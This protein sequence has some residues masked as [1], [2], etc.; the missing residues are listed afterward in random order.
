MEQ[1][2]IA[3][4]GPT[5]LMLACELRLAGADP[6]VIERLAAP[7]GESRAGGLHPRTLEILDMRGMIEPFL[8]EGRPLPGGHFAG[9]RLDFSGLDTKYPYLLVILQRRI[10]RL[11][12]AHARSLGVRF[13]REASVTGFAQRDDDVLIES[14]AGSLRAEYLVGC[15]GGRSTIRRSA[16]IE[17]LGTPPTMTAILGDVELAAPP[18]EPFFQASGEGGVYSVLVFEPGWYRVITNE[19]GTVADRDAPVGIDELR[20]TMVRLAGTDFGMHS[21]RWVSRYHDGARLASAYRAGRVLLAGDAAHIHYPAGGQGLNTGIQDAVNLGWKLAAVVG[22]AH[23]QDLLDSYAVERRPVAS[24]VLDNTRAQTAL[25]R[26]DPQTRALRGVVESLIAL[27]DVNR[28]LAEMVTALDIR[29]PLGEGAGH[30]A[31]DR[32]LPDGSHLFDHLRSGCPVLLAPSDRPGGQRPENVTPDR[33]ARPTRFGGGGGGGAAAPVSR[34]TSR[35]L[36][37]P[38]Y[39]RVKATDG[40]AM[41]IRP[42]GHVAWVEAMGEAARADALIRWC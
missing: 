28:S 41:L 8:A 40:P 22:N 23:D 32:L 10:E 25:T 2:V 9:L 7:S 30:R 34:S 4:G 20:A 24:R 29:Y 13:R 31:A 11:L 15:D 3:G 33:L 21:P 16:G 38:P 5:G 37:T 42:D 1:V 6:L 36:S 19:F 39:V 35:P 27:P 17:F 18:A 12:E 26:V 14:T